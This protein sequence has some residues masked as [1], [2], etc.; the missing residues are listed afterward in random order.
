MPS[1][2]QEFRHHLHE[3]MMETSD[4]LRDELN[5][6]KNNLVWQAQ[7][8]NNS[9][10]IPIA[11]SDSA[12]YAFR[13]RVEATIKSYLDALE[14]CGIVVDAIV[15][16]EMLREISPLTSGPK[17]LS[18]PP[19]VT[20]PTVGA[21]QAEHARK[22]ERTGNALY[23]EA[24]NRLRELKMKAGSTASVNVPAPTMPQTTPFTIASVVKT[25]AELKALPMDE[26][27][28]LLLRRLVQIYPT[29]KNADKFNKRNILLPG[30]KYQV[31]LGFSDAERM[32]VLL[33]L[34]GGPWTRLVNKGYLVDPSGSAF[35]DIPEEGFAAAQEA[36]RPTETPNPIAAPEPVDDGRPTIFISYSYDDDEHKEWV[37]Q[38]A[39]RLQV[40][41]GVNVILDR[42]HL[43]KGQ[44]KTHFME[45]SIVRSKFVLVVCTPEYARKANERIG[46]VGYEAMIITGKLAQDI[47]QAKFIP[48]LR[49]GEW[50][51]ALPTWLL[52]RI[53]TD[54][55]GDPYSEEQYEDLVRELHGAHLKPPSLGPKPVFP[56]KTYQTLPGSPAPRLVPRVKL[57]DKNV[58]SIDTS[59]AKPNAI[60]Y[61]FYETK[62]PGA[63]Q[64]KMFVRPADNAGERFTLE[65]SDG[66]ISEGSLA[67][68]ARDYHLTDQERLQEGYTHTHTSNASGRKEFDLA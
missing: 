17:S 3:L 4:R 26:Q 12:V 47:L 60:A 6:Y 8:R 64:Y 59:K 25:L 49:A 57:Q 22:M 13:T 52:S 62:G 32:P 65:T 66:E 39:A 41:G 18:L 31:A 40:E 68:I 29:V 35:F 14:K 34:L 50:D 28:M 9:A 27:A 53:G 16:S 1:L 15:E 61:A 5:G 23:R 7:Q 21:V 58:A 43:R 67:E 45:T 55:K 2:S 63:K 37:L 48:V 24:K 30:D 33:H 54:L 10:G 19:G 11:Y 46:G 38:L 20:G 44:D 36:A 56:E 42:W 51:S